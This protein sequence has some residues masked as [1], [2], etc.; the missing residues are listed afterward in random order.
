MQVDGVSPY[1]WQFLKIMDIVF[2]FSKVKLLL[3]G[4][5]QVRTLMS[6]VATF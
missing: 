5:D 2:F 1:K 4:T 6:F 3:K